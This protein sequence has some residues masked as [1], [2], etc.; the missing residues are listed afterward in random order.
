MLCTV[1]Q[2]L[3]WYKQIECISGQTKGADKECL[4]AQTFRHADISSGGKSF[5]IRSW[6]NWVS[7][8]C[9]ETC[10]K[11]MIGPPATW[12]CDLSQD[13]RKEVFQASGGLLM[14]CACALCLFHFHFCFEKLQFCFYISF[15][16]LFNTWF[17]L[18][19][20]NATINRWTDYC[21]NREIIV[22]IIGCLKNI[23]K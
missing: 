6:V 8:V 16:I 3:L 20:C 17:R 15:L 18:Q 4:H 21:N 14:S 11:N 7:D 10:K 12:Q 9:M 19:R 2:T 22:V 5:S 13:P 23:A 1:H